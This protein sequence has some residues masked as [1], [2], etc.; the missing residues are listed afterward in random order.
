[1]GVTTAVLGCDV[2]STF[3]WSGREGMYL[4][5]ASHGETPEGWE[6]LRVVRLTSAMASTLLAAFAPTGLV[7]LDRL[8]VDD[9]VRR[10]ITAAHGLA[11]AIFVPL[12]RGD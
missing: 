3:L 1:C 8:P 5:A 11:A 2:S 6:A 9:P 4:A 7:R 10:S 12:W